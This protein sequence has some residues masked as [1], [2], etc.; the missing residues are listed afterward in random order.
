[1]LY[2]SLDHCITSGAIKVKFCGSSAQHF[3]VSG[4]QLKWDL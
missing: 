2:I 1:M 4:S 3:L